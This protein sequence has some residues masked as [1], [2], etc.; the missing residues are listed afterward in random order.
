MLAE[1]FYKLALGCGPDA[2]DAR[3]VRDTVKKQR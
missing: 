2:G 3:S 1:E